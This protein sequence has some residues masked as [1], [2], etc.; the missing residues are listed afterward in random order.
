MKQTASTRRSRARNGSVPASESGS[1]QPGHSS[2]GRGSQ[3][4]LLDFASL[5]INGDETAEI[6]K[7]LLESNQR[8]VSLFQA[9]SAGLV[10]AG[11]RAEIRACNRAAL[12]LLGLSEDQLIGKTACDPDWH[13]IFEDGRPC[14]GGDRPIPRAIATRQPVRDVVV[15][16]FRPPCQDYVWLLVDARPRL[17]PDGSVN[18]VI[19][20]FVD[21]TVHRE[22]LRNLTASINR[23]EAAA[24]ASGQ[25]LYDWDTVSS[26]AVYGGDYERILGY[27]A[28]ELTGGLPRFM[29]LIHPDDHDMVWAGIE[30][31]LGTREPYRRDYRVRSKEGRYILARDRGYAYLDDSR[32]VV[33]MAGFISDITEQRH[34]E[35][36]LRAS[37]QRF[38][39]AFA[40][41]VTGMMLLDVQGRFIEANAA[42]CD[43]TG[44]TQAE[45]A[46]LTFLAITHPEDVQK[47]ASAF[48]QLLAGQSPSYVLEKRYLRKDGGVVWARVSSMLVRDAKTL[49]SHIV[50]IAE[51]VTERK[52]AEEE[53]GALSERLLRVQDEERRRLARELHDCTAQNIAAMCMNLGVV[54]E[55]SER[56]DRPAQK[57]LRECLE[58]GEQCIRE[59]RTFS[60]L[61]HPPVLDDLGL[62]SALRWYVDGFSQ[63]S[64]IEIALDVAPDLGRLPRELEL[65]LYRIVQESL[66]NIHRHSGSCTAVIRIVRH[67]KDVFMQVRDQGHG[68]SHGL[69]PDKTATTRVG[70]GI[71]SMRER[72]RQAGGRLKIRSRPT[73]T[74][75]EVLMPLSHRQA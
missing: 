72:V 42:F 57:A 51:D 35:E 59:L 62:C 65:T 3:P 26:D 63:R 49:P 30:R 24:R 56:L 71:A 38:R 48:E 8:F 10:L 58:L 36:E 25:I 21:V 1:Q 7:A 14:L 74:D 69:S 6:G 37:E 15:G 61:L 52:R 46:S 44:Y 50:T 64:G 12:E 41:A 54:S 67:A 32:N 33:R 19:C 20:S 70:V 18:E 31:V 66:T 27:S 39:A 29:E 43:I 11:P 55:S 73:G 22:T 53:L 47:S 60:Y 4:D 17:A 5:K 23:Y 16:F 13:I 2:P 28:E 75:V 45:L 34:A 68:I 9:I 40:R